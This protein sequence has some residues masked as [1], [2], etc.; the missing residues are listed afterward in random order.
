LLRI[1]LVNL[2]QVPPEAYEKPGMAESFVLVAST[3]LVRF[4]VPVDVLA[5]NLLRERRSELVKS[6]Q[7]EGAFS[8]GPFGIKGRFGCLQIAVEQ[9]KVNV[10]VKTPFAS[11]ESC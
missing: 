4:D 1:A 10:F 11:S 5:V 8:V 2:A 6:L 3:A 7:K 9:Q